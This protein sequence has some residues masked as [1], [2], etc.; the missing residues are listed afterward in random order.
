M[1]FEWTKSLADMKIVSERPLH[2]LKGIADGKLVAPGAPE[3][4]VLLQRMN[5]RG[6]G[7]M[8]IIATHSVHQQAVDVIR[9]WI[10]EMETKK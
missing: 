7:Q 3:R 6:T 4:S 5:T 1:H 10:R 9:Q 2:G 8:P